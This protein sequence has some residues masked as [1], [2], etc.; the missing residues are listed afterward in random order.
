[1]F[2]INEAMLSVG[3]VL[4]GFA[5]VLKGDCTDFNKVLLWSNGLVIISLSFLRAINKLTDTLEKILKKMK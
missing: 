3:C 5:I 4:I 2:K 1:M